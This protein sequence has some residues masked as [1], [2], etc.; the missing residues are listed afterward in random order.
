MGTIFPGLLPLLEPRDLHVMLW[1]MP[2]LSSGWN[3]FFGIV[4]PQ[5]GV[6]MLW[7]QC[8][9]FSLLLETTANT[10]AV[11]FE[12]VGAEISAMR[13]T[14]LPNRLALD[15]MLAKEGGVC[16]L[17]GSSCCMYIPDGNRSLFENIN[18]LRQAVKN[19]KE[20]PV[21][22]YGSFDSE[23]IFGSLSG[24]FSGL[25]GKILL[26]LVS[27]LSILFL[28][29]IIFMVIKKCI[30]TVVPAVALMTVTTQASVTGSRR[31]SLSGES[32]A[33]S[34]RSIVSQ[35]SRLSSRTL[36]NHRAQSVG[37]LTPSDYGYTPMRKGNTFK[38]E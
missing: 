18:K 6:N 10:T 8:K 28:L 2:H 21:T 11:G 35:T 34:V 12:I 33:P 25:G 27:V 17:I 30:S 7:E 36:Q 19:Y 20:G 15:M 29:C 9:R 1:L 37:S 13:T 38:P 31:S 16:K 3:R 5:L 24:L 4:I 32:R 26:F 22:P 23:G 14:V